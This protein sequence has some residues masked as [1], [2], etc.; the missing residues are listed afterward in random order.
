M[1]DQKVCN[2]V[3]SVRKNGMLFSVR[4][5]RELESAAKMDKTILA[6]RLKPYELG[7]CRQWSVMAKSFKFRG[8]TVM[9]YHLY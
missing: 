4:K 8:K 6:E 5:I 1:A 2:M 3:G 9:L 7:E